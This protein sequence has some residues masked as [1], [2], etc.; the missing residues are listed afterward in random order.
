MDDLVAQRERDV[1][2]ERVELLLH[3]SGME[4]AVGAEL[5]EQAL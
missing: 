1:I 5:R 2:I 3:L 4:V